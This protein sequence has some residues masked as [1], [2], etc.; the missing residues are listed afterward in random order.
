MEKPQ[1]I[2]W[3]PEMYSI[4]FRMPTIVCFYVICDCKPIVIKPFTLLVFSLKTT[5]KHLN[6]VSVKFRALYI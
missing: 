1:S 5:S 4:E 2:E 3:L 6:M